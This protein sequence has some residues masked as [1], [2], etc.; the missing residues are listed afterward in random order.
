MPSSA[1]LST[2]PILIT[3]V[4]GFIG[5]TVA[6]QLLALGQSV[7]GIDNLNDYYDPRLKRAR[8][9]QLQQPGFAFQALDLAD[10]SQVQALFDQIRPQYVVHLAAQAG[11]RYAM[12]NPK[13]Y[14]DSNL[15]GSSAILEACRTHKVR[16]LV[17][18]SSSSVYGGNQKVPFSERDAVDHPV[19][20]YA[21]SKRSNELMA[22]S[23]SHLYNLPITM[24]R[25]F[26][27]Y[28]PWG[29]PDMAIWKFTDA[30]LRGQPIDVYAQGRLSRDFTFVEDAAHA[31]IELLKRPSARVATSD[32]GTWRSE[33][34]AT[35][36]APFETFNI[37]RS[38]PVTVNELIT[39]LEAATG[40]TALRNEMPM[41]AGDVEKTYADTSKLAAAI[42]FEPRTSLADG[43]Q[44]FVRWFREYRNLR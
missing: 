16:H 5:S 34:P 20:F 15:A 10:W 22:H 35:S 23:Y 40:H 28:G 1:P 26:T 38:D 4:A 12:T 14:S 2:V 18:A 6:R 25:Y 13:A 33:G 43:L 29:R 24:L 36:W 19:S 39:L 41:Q 3:G 44:Q 21:A 9:K 30:M 32:P 27:V 7:F 42:G 11:V 8:L 17:F 37:G 31:T